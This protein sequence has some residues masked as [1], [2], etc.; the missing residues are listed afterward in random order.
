[1]KEP[2]L[3]SAK[4]R[5]LTAIKSQKQCEVLGVK[6]SKQALELCWGAIKEQEEMG[7]R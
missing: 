7:T 5:S 6:A 3:S 1:M 4:K 2:S